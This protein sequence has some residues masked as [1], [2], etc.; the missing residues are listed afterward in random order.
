MEEE[1]FEGKT[2]MVDLVQIGTSESK[3]L[4]SLETWNDCASV[5]D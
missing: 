3:R 5:F 4:K 1:V 2:V